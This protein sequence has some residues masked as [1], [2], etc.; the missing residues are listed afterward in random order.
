M[1][2]FKSFVYVC[3]FVL[4][5]AQLE[6]D[7]TCDF[8]SENWLENYCNWDLTSISGDDNVAIRYDEDDS[9]IGNKALSVN[10]KSHFVL[11]SRSDFTCLEILHDNFGF[12]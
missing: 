10:G 4:I 5:A 2:W 11:S 7:I 6:Q 1:A 8:E 3:K 9:F 12:R